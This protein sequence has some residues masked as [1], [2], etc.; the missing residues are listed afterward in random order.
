VHTSSSLRLL[1]LLASGAAF[2]CGAPD[3]EQTG[4]VILDEDARAAGIA[5]VAD[6]ERHDGALP[7]ALDPG[8][9]A[10]VDGP[11]VHETIRVNPVEVVEIRGADGDIVRSHATDRLVIRSSESSA[12]LLADM[13]DARLG[14][15]RDG[16][17]ELH[18]E[19]VLLVA[20]MLDGI[21]ELFSASALAPSDFVFGAGTTEVMAGMP[22]VTMDA[23]QLDEAGDASGA[24]LDA[25]SVV[26]LYRAA[27][28]TMILDAAGGYR[29]RVGPKEVQSG[30]WSVLGRSVVL[31]AADGSAPARLGVTNNS[32]FDAVGVEYIAR[33][34]GGAL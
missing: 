4:F 25:S 5:V 6:G 17:Y 19:N 22:R 15:R 27:S 12:T 18:G 7:I 11:N 16:R 33:L 1:A 9:T 13:L 3:P 32:V 2:A 14:R 20:S 8:Q 24:P 31:H 26:G 21:P 10:L 28:V 30:T 34:P 29:T 23:R